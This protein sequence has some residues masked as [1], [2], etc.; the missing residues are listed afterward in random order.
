[1]KKILLAAVL[2]PLSAACVHTVPPTAVQQPLSARPAQPAVAAAANG[3]IFQVGA[4]DRALFEDRRARRVGDTLTISISERTAASRKSNTNSARA[5][6]NQFGV[7]SLAG[8]PGKS[9]LN[10]NLNATSDF[11]FDGSGESASNND[12]NG[13][14][15]VTV[16]EVLANG[17]LQVSGEK[18]LGIN[19]GSEFIRFSGIVNPLHL[20][21]S[22]TVSST[23][24]ADAR[25]EYRANGALDS[26]QVMGWLSRF[27]LNFLPF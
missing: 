2:L 14:I 4:N 11:S 12:F 18:Q 3:A 17:N 6:N 26:A 13:V 7:N 16:I 19:Q 9:F 1:M 20:T 8:L 25:I 21:S 27:F 24:V 15:T 10:S 5:S 23:Q 22:N